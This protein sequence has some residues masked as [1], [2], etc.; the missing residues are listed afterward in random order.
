METGTTVLKRHREH[1][2]L[3]FLL[4]YVPIIKW[5]PLQAKLKTNFYIIFKYFRYF[6]YESVMG[7]QCLY[8][9]HTL[10]LLKYSKTW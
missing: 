8:I 3:E 2:L 1:L 5:A 4:L 6:Q 10:K 7:E 9:I